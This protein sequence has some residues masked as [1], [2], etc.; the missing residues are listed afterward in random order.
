[1]LGLFLLAT[2]VA[3]MLRVPLKRSASYPYL[4]SLKDLVNFP[5]NLL[6]YSRSVEDLDNYFNMQYIGELEVGTPPQNL[7]FIFDTGSSWLWLP[8]TDCTSCHNS[9]Q[10]DP[11]AST[12]FNTTGFELNLQYGKGSASGVISSDTVSFGSPKLT[13]ADQPFILV[14]R[15]EDLDG[16][17]ADGVLG[18]AFD[19]LSDGY[20]TF[21]QTLKAQGVIDKAIFSFYLNDN[22]F[23]DED[24][25]PRSEVMIGGYDAAKYTSSQTIHWMK[26]FNSG[27]WS[28]TLSKV[29]FGDAYLEGPAAVAIIDTGT[30]LLIGPSDQVA[31][32]NKAIFKKHNDYCATTDEGLT[33]CECDKIKDIK[34]LSFIFERKEY[35]IASKHLFLEVFGFCVMLVQPWDEDIWILGNV[36]LRRYYSIYDMDNLQIGFVRIEHEDDKDDKDDEDDGGSGSSES[37]TWKILLIILGCLAAVLIGVVGYLVYRS[38]RNRKLRSESYKD[39]ASIN[40][41]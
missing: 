31:Q 18:L 15:D 5:P 3:A 4:D 20:P 21:V 32:I 25:E 8:S 35:Y 11:S 27:Y 41:A 40:S 33:L 39:M 19:S 37:S 9:K 34:G 10:F 1:M 30:S 36:F 23:S 7:T 28:I 29:K 14:N 38:R 13:V 2:S 26:V 16:L 12:T 24:V 6:I 22:D 17:D